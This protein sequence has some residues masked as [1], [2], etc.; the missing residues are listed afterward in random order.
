MAFHCGSNPACPS[1]KAH[2]NPH[3]NVFLNIG[4]ARARTSPATSCS[5][6]SVPLMLPPCH[7]CLCAQ[8]ALEMQN[9]FS[10]QVVV[11]MNYATIHGFS[12]PETD[13]N[14][15]TNDNTFLHDDDY[16]RM[17]IST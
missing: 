14:S 11:R 15:F 13:V 1:D 17:L 8:H 5:T 12:L 16:N 3:F 2:M 9:A 6:T 7:H 10:A 4:T